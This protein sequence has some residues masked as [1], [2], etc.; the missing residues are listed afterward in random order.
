[1]TVFTPVVEVSI[2]LNE[3]LSFISPSKLST[4]D[5]IYDFKSTCAP[6][7]RETLFVDKTISGP[8]ISFTVA[9]KV[10]FEVFP[11]LSL[12]ITVNVVC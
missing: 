12:T 1:M 8:V 5:V 3:I 4:A 11:A 6:L 9:F 7:S 10:S 2:V